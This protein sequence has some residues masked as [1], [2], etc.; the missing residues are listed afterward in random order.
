VITHTTTP[1]SD[2]LR[3]SPQ[4]IDPL[5]WITRPWV[6]LS[7]ALLALVYGMTATLL[8][9]PVSGRPWFDVAGVLCVFAACLW[10]QVVTRP[11]RPQFT[12]ARAVVPLLLALTGLA[13]STVASM[14]S[15]VAVHN[16]WAP[17]GMGL[18]IATCAP[19]STLPQIAAYGGVLT[20]FTGF[21][22]WPA[23]IGR[24]D[25]WTGL[26]TVAIACSSVIVGTVATGVF[27]FGVVFTTQRVLSRAGIPIAEDDA[28]REAAARR[29]EI[30]TLARLGSR[31]APFL[32]RVAD[33]GVVTEA[34][35]ALAGQLARRLR[36]DLVTQ[37]NRS[38]LDSLALGE[39]IYVVDPD[40]R[41]D[42]M[43]AAQ[44]AALRGLLLTVIADPAT[45]SGSLFIELRGQD[46]GSTAVAMS[47]DIDLPEGRRIMMIAPYYVALKAIVNEISWDPVHDLLRFRVPPGKRW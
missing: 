22:T 17:V 12:P 26:S 13:F 45:D 9:L 2:A 33:A 31:V 36:S 21:A 27:C 28:L 35:R 10:V 24:D 43:N 5:S 16:W 37:A 18:V 40:N 20:F 44:R 14:V 41:A 25:P 15:E 11:L 19:Y 46:D 32:D 34:D 29:A 47:I 38:W 3:V 7:F 6:S 4:Q 1:W 42:S 8:I 30:S 39:R 23:F